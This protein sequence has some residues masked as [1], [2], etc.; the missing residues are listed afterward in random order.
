MSSDL[1]NSKI[2]ALCF[3]LFL[4]QEQEIREVKKDVMQWVK[5]VTAHQKQMTAV[6]RVEFF[7]L[8]LGT[9]DIYT[10]FDGLAYNTCGYFASCIVF[11]RAPQG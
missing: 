6:V 5:D 10:L 4:T 1:F 7:V 9:Y 3:A 8:F 11:F 2:E